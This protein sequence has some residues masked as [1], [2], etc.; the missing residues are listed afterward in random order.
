MHWQTGDAQGAYSDGNPVV[1]TC[2]WETL[3]LKNCTDFV[4]A[5]LATCFWAGLVP[6]SALP[7]SRSRS[8]RKLLEA[9]PPPPCFLAWRAA[10]TGRRWGFK[11]RGPDV[12]Q[13]LSPVCARGQATTIHVTF[14]PGRWQDFIS[15]DFILFCKQLRKYQM[16]TR[17]HG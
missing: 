16:W 15:L 17:T 1:G 2:A 8:L 4:S 9:A 13:L 14:L 12:I 6:V 7:S 10:Q 11:A 5:F 3:Q